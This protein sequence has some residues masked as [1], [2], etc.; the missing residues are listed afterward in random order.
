MAPR[1]VGLMHTALLASK[2]A[3]FTDFTMTGTM[4]SSGRTV[5]GSLQG[6]GFTGESFTMVKQ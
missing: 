1:N 2:L 5:N 4:E 3:P 6:S